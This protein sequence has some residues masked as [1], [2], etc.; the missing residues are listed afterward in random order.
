ML[1]QNVALGSRSYDVLIGHNILDQLVGVLKNLNAEQRSVTIITED[2]VANLYLEKIKSLLESTDYQVNI[3]ILPAGESTK[4]LENYE[5]CMHFCLQHNVERNH[6]LIAL[7]G[8]VIGDLT[9]FVAATLRRGCRFIQVPT[10]L[11]AQV[12]SSVG[13]KTAI[14][15][16]YGKNLI[17]AFYQPS[18]VLIDVNFLGTLSKRVYRSGYAEVIKYGL[19]GDKE[20]FNYLAQNNDLFLNQDIEF[21]IK[22]IAHCV[23]MKA[24]IVSRDE[25]EKGERALLNLGHTFAHAYEAETGYSDTLHHGEAVAL[26]MLNAAQFSSFQGHLNTNIV[27]NIENVLFAAGFNL[28]IIYYIS[29]LNIDNILKHMMQDKKV[30]NYRLSLILL[31]DIGHS[32]IQPDSCIKELREFFTLNN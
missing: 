3:L 16:Q 1:T 23:E 9:G 12:D 18:A 24:N 26:G 4:S 7:G 13:G 2:T 28:N 21:L 20:F 27:D 15:C 32:F 14:N 29:D 5:R 25:T 30:S 19:L 22:I 10:T 11:L 31:K 17:G 6:A 8:G